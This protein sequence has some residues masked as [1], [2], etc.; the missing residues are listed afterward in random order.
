MSDHFALMIFGTVGALLQTAGLIFL[1]LQVRAT[2]QEIQVSLREVRRDSRRMVRAL[3]RLM[4]GRP[5]GGTY[6]S[7]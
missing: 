5:N 4:T 1:V 7:P 6:E 2:R 3:A